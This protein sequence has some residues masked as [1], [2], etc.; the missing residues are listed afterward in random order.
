VI[1][2][3]D[4]DGTCVTHE[5]PE[6]GRDIGAQP[7]LKEMVAKG[8]QLILWTMRDGICLAQ[9]LDWFK[10]NDIPLGSVN[11]N[12]NQVVWT[13]SPKAYA[14]LYIDDAAYGAPLIEG[15]AGERPHFDWS[16]VVNDPT[17]Y[18]QSKT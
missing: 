15:L 7:V 5:Y 6:I 12:P 8:H 16:K 4:F 13:D 3:V 1:I 17:F 11:E 2:A 18:E 9:A 14:Q 10:R